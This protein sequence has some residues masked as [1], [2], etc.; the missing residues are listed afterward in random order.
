MEMRETFL[1]FREDD[2]PLLFKDLAWMFGC[3]VKEVQHC[4]D[5]S[6]P[7]LR[8]EGF[9]QVLK[10]KIPKVRGAVGRPRKA[11]TH[12]GAQKEQDVQR[13]AQ[14][15]EDEARFKEWLEGFEDA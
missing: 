9:G 5:G 15:L 13:R 3:N 2:C 7:M 6:H 14:R 1:Y 8:D 4:M 12:D 10:R 11:G